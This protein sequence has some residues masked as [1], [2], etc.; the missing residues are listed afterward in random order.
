MAIARL[1]VKVGS[2]GKAQPHAD[3]ISREGKYKDRL[4]KGEKLEATDTGN[5]PAWAAHDSRIFWQAADTYERKNGSTYREHEIALPRELSPDQRLDLVND[6]VKSEIGNNHAYQFAIHTPTASDGEE[7]PHCHLMFCERKH[8]GI[9]RDPDQY[10]KRYNK[11][12]PERGGAQKTNFSM[13][14]SER[15]DALKAQRERWQ[16]LCNDHL[17]RA[18]HDVEI[19]MRSYADQGIAK[20]PE[21]KMLPSEWQDSAQKD[22]ILQF[23]EARAKQEQATAAIHALIPDVDRQITHLKEDAQ[24]QQ[25]MK[26]ENIKKLFNQALEQAR[27][28]RDTAV[29]SLQQDLKHWD[30]LRTEHLQQRPIKQGILGRFSYQTRTEAWERGLQQIDASQKTIADEVEQVKAAP[31]RQQAENALRRKHPLLADEYQRLEALAKQQREQKRLERER[32][33]QLKQE[34]QQAELVKERQQEREK[35]AQQHAEDM[36]QRDKARE[37]RQIDRERQRQFFADVLQR[38]NKQE[39]AKYPALAR[40][41]RD[42]ESQAKYTGRPLDELIEQRAR[43]IKEGVRRIE[44]DRGLDLSR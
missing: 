42:A 9:A 10:F 14:S 7:Q 36:A 6:W 26:P 43:Q 20:T 3:Y 1:S 34:R 24:H 33:Q 23:R 39:I 29:E 38:Q 35:Q 15:R 17:K 13:K 2:V 41:Q 31:V 25:Q 27:Q 28:E 5:M 12:N 4:D 30:R 18:G 40:I 16:T 44:Q 8:D 37:Q 22:T 21:P 32:Q 19:D 11:K